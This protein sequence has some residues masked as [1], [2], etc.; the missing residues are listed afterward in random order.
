MKRLEKL[1]SIRIEP[2]THFSIITVCNWAR[3]QDPTGK[4]EQP[5]GRQRAGNGQATGTYKKGENE[6]NGQEGRESET[7]RDD[8]KRASWK[9]E[10]NG[11]VFVWLGRVR[12][13]LGWTVKNR[14]WIAKV[15]YMVATR[16]VGERLLVSGLEAVKH[17]NGGFKKTAAGFLYTTLKGEE[18]EFERLLAQTPAPPESLWP[19]FD[20][21]RASIAREPNNGGQRDEPED[22]L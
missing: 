17:H 1:G 13:V 6:K 9:K 18:P 14:E 19:E 7:G 12:A 10:E 5:T 21:Y 3:Y 4:S 11:N 20:R 16:K 22:P 15:C 2:G 8:H